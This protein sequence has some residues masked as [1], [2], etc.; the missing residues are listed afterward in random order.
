MNKTFRNYAIIWA[1]LLAM[2]NVAAFVSPAE[3]AGMSKFGGAFW[4]G[5]IFITVAFFGQLAVAYYAFRAQ[6]NAQKFFYRVPLI[7][8]SWTGLILT[9]VFG[10]ACMIIPNLPNWVGVIVC[11]VILGFNAIALAKADAAADLVET[12]DE[13]IKV[14]TFFI[15]SLTVDAE[16]LLARAKSEAAK[17]A[18]KKVYEAVRYSDP[19]SHD[20]LTSAESAITLKFSKFS[21]AVTS[22]NAELIAASADEL[23]ILI[24]DRNKK[25]K[26]LK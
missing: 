10:S 24:G 11:F 4:S 8:V 18:C 9:L 23:V 22:D 21:E 26:L 12:V 13:K 20:A 15:R 2:F 16:S 14:Q 25:C 19:M 7:T 5:Y 1:A 17:A 3:M 6:E